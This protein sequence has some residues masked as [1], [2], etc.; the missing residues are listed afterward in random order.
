MPPRL[1]SSTSRTH[2]PNNVLGVAKLIYQTPFFSATTLVMF[3]FQLVVIFR[4]TATLC[5][6]MD[7][8]GWWLHMSKIPRRSYS[9]NH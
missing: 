6:G 7:T 1:S 9:T 8:P 3:N 5:D 4:M 2:V